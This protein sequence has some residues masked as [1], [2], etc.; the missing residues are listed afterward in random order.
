MCN[1][2]TNRYRAHGAPRH[3]GLTGPDFYCIRVRGCLDG[4]WSAWFDGLLV[5]ADEAC[6][7]TAICGLVADQAAL[8]S[9]LGKVSNL[10]LVLLEVTRP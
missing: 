7:E 10:G 9:L 3:G 5:E 4:S 1:D 6:G 2:N 8:H